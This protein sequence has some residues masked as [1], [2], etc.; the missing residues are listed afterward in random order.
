MTQNTKMFRLG[1][2]ALVLLTLPV[3]SGCATSRGTVALDVAQSTNPA[4][5]TAVRIV[6]VTDNRKFEISPSSPATPSLKDNGIHDKALTSRAIAR[7]RNGYGMAMGDVLL[8]EGNTVESLV[9]NLVTQSLREA[10]FRVLEANQTGYENA[11]PLDVGIDKFWAWF[12]PGFWAAHLEFESKIQISGPVTPFKDGK[13]FEG[14][15]RLATQ[16]ATTGAWQNTIHKGMQNLRQ[17]IQLHA[18]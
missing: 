9:Q 17:D 12:A 14:R 3:V 13:T 2:M 5:G 1:F 18:R 15:V 4:T 8:S 7:K 10:G 16:A 11:I 6:S